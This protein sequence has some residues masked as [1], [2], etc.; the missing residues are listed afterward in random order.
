MQ[1]DFDRRTNAELER[2]AHH[3]VGPLPLLS[4]ETQARL[5][6]ARAV[7]DVDDLPPAYRAL[8]AS[9]LPPGESLPYSVL[10]PTFAGHVRRHHEHLVF[11]L[12]DE[13]I[14]V[15]RD[16]ERL[17]TTRFPA[18][19][20]HWVEVGDILLDGW[21]TLRGS[22][23]SRSTIT[24]TLRFNAVGDHLFTPFVEMSRAAPVALAGVD[25]ATPTRTFE[26]LRELDFKF[27][28]FGLRAVRS[29]DRLVDW[30]F[31]PEIRTPVATVLGRSLRRTRALA[32]LL[33][34]TDAELIIIRD[35]AHAPT[36]R[37]GRHGGAWTYVAL[38]RI[39]GVS[40]AER[41]PGLHAVTVRLP[42]GDVLEALFTDEARAGLERLCEQ[43]AR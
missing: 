43:L 37:W 7:Q 41:G 14:V 19:C 6:W 10:T 18:P 15:E 36:S 27:A 23:R 16:R 26:G 5:S 9:L 12:G 35:C 28:N 22:T 4:A 33:I 30:V 13:I 25:G 8:M 42:D 1:R 17:A 21:I 24:S 29:G 20:L 38:D 31:Q 39:A 34:L 3:V 11:A 40:L 32:H 2:M